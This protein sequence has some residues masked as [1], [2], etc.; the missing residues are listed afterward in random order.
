MFGMLEEEELTDL[1]QSASKTEKFVKKALK[2]VSEDEQKILQWILQPKSSRP[3]ASQIL[4]N[5]YFSSL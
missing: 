4:E 2:T 1:F 5:T 3:T